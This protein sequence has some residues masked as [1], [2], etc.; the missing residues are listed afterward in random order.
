MLVQMR[1]Q[2][3]VK[4][5]RPRDR[6]RPPGIPAAKDVQAIPESAG[7]TRVGHRALV[8]T[9]Q[10]LSGWLP[11]IFA[12]L[13]SVLGAFYVFT[14]PPLQVPDEFAHLYR[15]YGLSE[16]YFV[17]PRLTPMPASI[18]RLT[19]QFPPHLE[20]V[21][22][23]SAAELFALANEPLRPEYQVFVGNPGMNVNTWIPYVPSSIAIFIARHS[24][25]SPLTILYLGRLA[26]LA[27]YIII[28]WLAL[29][30]APPCRFALF[31]VALMPMVLH[32]AAGLSWDSIVFGIAFLFCAL[33][34]RYVN[35]DISVLERRD[36]IAIF[37]AALVVSLC[38]ADFALLPLLLLI[39][40]EKFRALRRRMTFLGICVACAVATSALWQYVNRVN[41][42]L[43]AESASADLKVQF[44]DNIW[45]IYYNTGYVINAF[46][47]DVIHRSWV[48][49]TEFVGTF[50]WLFV[51][52][53]D[54]AVITYLGLLLCAGIASLGD[55][56]LSWFQRGVLLCAVLLGSGSC[57]LAMWLATP[58][59][60][61][62]DAILHDVGT[63]Y[64][65]QGRHFIPFV[66]AGLLFLS[67][68]FLRGRLLWLLTLALLVII[69]VNTTAIVKIRQSYY[70]TQLEAAH[71]SQAQR[72]TR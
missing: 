51:Q 4:T 34:M 16:G 67:N 1:H 2:A 52:L 21:R 58:N 36:Y 41:M 42:Q 8:T 50:G 20:N 66:F 27:G 59:F 32:Q 70:G 53:P 14:T 57:V 63:L 31:T 25:A 28:M 65:I 5:R 44:P 61:I 9:D 33:V 56:R 37:I 69:T 13:C 60:Y 17:A 22:K 11:V 29:R 49:A 7:V 55:L 68:R 15:A 18:A 35:R 48:H 45:Y 12:V 72:L 10:Y 6:D 54:W 30:L 24:G 40:T 64:G 3:P 19:A 46:F 39:P 26:N 62:Q 38:K 47:R 43:F 23:I 71:M